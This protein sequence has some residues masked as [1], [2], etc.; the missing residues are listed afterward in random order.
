MKSTNINN[1]EANVQTGNRFGKTLESGKDTGRGEL[2]SP[3]SLCIDHSEGHIHLNLHLS[4]SC[5]VAHK[6]SIFKNMSP[7]YPSRIISDYIRD[8]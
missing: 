7:L 2:K 6:V 8:D 4:C 3:T 5:Q 1:T